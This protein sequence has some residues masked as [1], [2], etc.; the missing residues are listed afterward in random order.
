MDKDG[1]VVSTASHESGSLV[2]CVAL[3]AGT[4]IGAG[5]LAMPAATVSVGFLPSTAALL[6]AWFYMTL[7]GLLIAELVINRVSQT[8]RTGVGLLDLMN[9]NL[10]GPLGTVGS[11]A[12]FFL[13]YAVMVA[14]I[15]QG[16]VNLGT[17]L[18]SVG[19]GSLSSIPGLDQSLYAL[20]VGLF[21]YW[22]KPSLAQGVNNALVLGTIASFTVIMGLAWDSSDFH[23]LIAAENQHPELVANAF[24]ILFLSMVYQNVVPEVVTRLECDRTKIIS[25]IVM[26]TS[27]PALMYIA[28]NGIILGNIMSLPE[29]LNGSLDPIALLQSEGH[30]GPVLSSAVSIFS[31]LAITTSLIGFIYGIINAFSDLMS[32]RPNNSIIST[33][34]EPRETTQST[35][36]DDYKPAFFAAAL[37]P[38]LALSVSD[39]DIFF[40]ALDYGGAFGVSTLFLVLPPL[41]IWKMRYGEEQQPLAVRPMVPFGKI[42]LASMWKAA[43]TLIIEQGAEKL[44]IIDYLKNLF[45]TYF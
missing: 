16:G 22:A 25:S 39:P 40:N 38:P 12:Y 10:G 17:V 33:E 13:H 27:I 42:P 3:I 43:G 8:G 24:P 45:T 6:V 36:F 32:N 7:S 2:A 1:Q 4:T 14:Y 34:T 20:I 18:D 28:W 35:T 26:G 29:V 23:S 37:I 11:V 30:A 44:G 41:M 15:F 5:A 19:L 9:K 21:V 31:E